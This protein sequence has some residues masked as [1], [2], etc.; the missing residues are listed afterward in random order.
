MD[1]ALAWLLARTS[2]DIEG[3]TLRLPFPCFG[4]AFTDR[5]TLEIAEALLQKDGGILAGQHGC[6]S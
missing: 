2:L 6:R 4:M 3:R 5:A 1:A